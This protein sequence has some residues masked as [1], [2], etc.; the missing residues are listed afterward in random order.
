MDQPAPSTPSAYEAFDTLKDGWGDVGVEI[1]T[2]IS[3][4]LKSFDPADSAV[5]FVF[6]G[7]VEWVLAAALF[8]LKVL[9]LPA[10]HN[11]A[12]FDLQSV[13][14]SIDGQKKSLWSV[15]SS[16]TKDNAS[17]KLKNHHG[18]SKFTMHPTVFVDPYLGGLVLIDPE[19]HPEI[20]EHVE[21]KKDAV[22]LKLSIIKEHAEKYPDCFIPAR[23]PVKEP[24]AFRPPAGF[25]QFNDIVGGDSLHYPNLG[26]LL[27]S[28][29]SG[30]AGVVSEIERIVSLKD[31]GKITQEQYEALFNK[32]VQ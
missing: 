25:D 13:L 3:T 4:F 26:A 30:G 18:G 1:E 32:L 29:R 15:K 20:M 31:D 16:S 9:A 8:H 24:G 27:A 28:T 23:L 6:G 5:R 14:E 2:A 12:D 21:N 10:G 17:I 7:Y 19:L 11:Q 22:Q